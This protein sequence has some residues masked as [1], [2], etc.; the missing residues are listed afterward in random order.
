M[1]GTSNIDLNLL[2]N[3]ERLR[4]PVILNEIFFA[5]GLY[6]NI[7]TKS[8]HLETPLWVKLT[9]PVNG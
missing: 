6:H 2:P 4:D 9:E 8:P 7:W 1:A 5:T 3:A